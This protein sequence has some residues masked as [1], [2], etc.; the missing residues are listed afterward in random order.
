M[1]RNHQSPVRIFSY[2]SHIFPAPVTT[3]QPIPTASSTPT[4]LSVAPTASAR[5]KPSAKNVPK[6]PL[7]TVA[8]ASTATTIKFAEK[9]RNWVDLV[10]ILPITVH[11]LLNTFAAQ[12]VLVSIH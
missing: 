5:R 1:R 4:T 8:L 3:A 7:T 10:T 12:V 9:H 2:F 6:R 11:A